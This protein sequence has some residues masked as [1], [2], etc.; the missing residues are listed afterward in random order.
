MTSAAIQRN[1]IAK[2]MKA[3]IHIPVLPQTMMLCVRG[4]QSMSA[5]NGHTQTCGR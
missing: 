3:A 4:H 2:A 5:M 1:R